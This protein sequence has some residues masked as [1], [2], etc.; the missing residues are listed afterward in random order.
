MITSVK[1]FLFCAGLLFFCSAN[2][3]LNLSEAKKIA[4]LEE[5]IMESVEMDYS[6]YKFYPFAIQDRQ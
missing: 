2:S 3:E 6:H 5:R 1:V 4:L